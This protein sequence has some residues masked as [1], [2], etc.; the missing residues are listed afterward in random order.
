MLPVPT[1]DTER[2][3]IVWTRLKPLPELFFSLKSVPAR[4]FRLTT[5]Q[6]TL[7][8]KR[9]PRGAG[10]TCLGHFQE[11]TVRAKPQLWLLEL[12]QTCSVKSP[13]A[14][15]CRFPPNVARHLSIHSGNTVCCT[16]KRCN[17]YEHEAFAR[18]KD[19]CGS[20]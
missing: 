4:T 11:A 17:K 9:G 13:Q 15:L 20:S 14:D 5:R 3:I 6:E 12:L 16:A 7:E 19:L 2:P 10:T 18:H 8:G 1:W